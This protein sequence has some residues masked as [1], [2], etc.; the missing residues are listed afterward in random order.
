MWAAL[1]VT[2]V[3]K[4]APAAQSQF[5]WDHSILHDQPEDELQKL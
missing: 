3:K 5:S 1:S 4:P 2:L